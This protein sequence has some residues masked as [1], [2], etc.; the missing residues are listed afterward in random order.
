MNKMDFSERIRFAIRSCATGPRSVLGRLGDERSQQ[1]SPEAGWSGPLLGRCHYKFR[2][3]ENGHFPVPVLL[4]HHW[5]EKTF[6][7]GNV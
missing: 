3:V 6:A 2:L 1:T 7:A 5:S 4:R